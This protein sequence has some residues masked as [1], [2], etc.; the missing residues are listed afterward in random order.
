AT[1]I[2]ITGRQQAEE[3]IR[4]LNEDLEHRVQ[5]RTSQLQA[6]N[7]ELENEIAERRR[8]EEAL[9]E[10]EA[11]F[12]RL[13]ES[14]VI[15]V[16]FSDLDG[17]IMEAND[18]F[19]DLVGYTRQQMLEGGLRWN[20]LTA[21]EYRHLDEEAIEELRRSRVCMPYEK[22]YIRSDGAR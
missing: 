2:D 15:G 7:R 9:R 1:G 16:H 5:E 19:L 4:K 10:S 13:P 21:A 3:E 6:T 17:N 20:T 8:A 22:E 12:H 14:N 11:Q 18:A